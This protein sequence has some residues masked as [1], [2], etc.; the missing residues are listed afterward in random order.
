MSVLVS[1]VCYFHR[2]SWHRYGPPWP[3]VW[4]ICGT[5]LRVCLGVFS[6][7]AGTRRASDAM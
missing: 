3:T 5:N 6:R 1:L 4:H 2:P 7:T